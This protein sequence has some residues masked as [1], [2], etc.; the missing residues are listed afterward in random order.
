MNILNLKNN[1]CI[2]GTSI[3][4]KTNNHKSSLGYIPIKIGKK[5]TRK[6]HGAFTGGFSAGYNNTVGSEAGFKPKKFL[7]SREKKN[8]NQKR[9]NIIE[10]IDDEDLMTNTDFLK[11]KSKYFSKGKKQRYAKT[12]NDI[13]NSSFDGV[14]FKK[15]RITTNKILCNWGWYPEYEINKKNIPCKKEQ[16]KNKK[17]LTLHPIIKLDTHG[18]GYH[19]DILD[20]TRNF[21]KL[22]AHF[23]K[24]KEHLDFFKKDNQLKNLNQN[25]KNDITEKII[26]KLGF[27]EAKRIE[28]RD[29]HF[30]GPN[31]FPYYNCKKRFTC[32]NDQTLQS[33]IKMKNVLQVNEEM[34]SFY[35]IFH[36]KRLE[37]FKKEKISISQKVSKVFTCKLQNFKQTFKTAISLPGK[38]KFHCSFV[39]RKKSLGQIQMQFRENFD[40]Q[41]R[42][43][44]FIKQILRK[45]SQYDLLFIK[46]IGRH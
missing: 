15:V 45:K 7:T 35:K 37:E 41:N 24:E 1:I 3:N 11:V 39:E 6:F 22:N 46:K 2:L 30:Q 9:Y 36:K 5:G 31:I 14:G 33:V 42:F 10:L 8:K 38:K 13:I 12:I 21:Q 44:S 17:Y 27:I 20:R 16:I 23:Q 4:I 28:T 19:K 18:L 32:G 26:E 25:I 43:I 29:K 40:K 34:F